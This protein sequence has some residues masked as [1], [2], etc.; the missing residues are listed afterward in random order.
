MDAPL[1]QS[2]IFYNIVQ[3]RWGVGRGL[4]VC[5]QANVKKTAEFVKA[6]WHIREPFKNYLAD[7]VR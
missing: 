7:F 5:G 1:Y 2:C 3:K 6:F 4:C